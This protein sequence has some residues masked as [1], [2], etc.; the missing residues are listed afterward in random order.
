MHDGCQGGRERRCRA[1]ARSGRGERGTLA[2]RPGLP[3]AARPARLVLSVL[4]AGLA[5]GSA[6]GCGREGKPRA[7]NEDAVVDLDR[8]FQPLRLDFEGA[9]GK[10]RLIGIVGPTCGHCLESL[11]AIH[12]RLLER[13][14]GRDFEVFIVWSAVMPADVRVRARQHAERWA[15]PRIRHYWDDSGRVARAFGQHA[16]LPEGRPISNL[17]YLYGR[18]DTWDPGGAMANEPPGWNA[19]L[20]GWQPAAARARWGEHAHLRLPVFDTERI[21]EKTEELLAEPGR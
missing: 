19:I 6:A 14:S 21:A 18:D 13:V 7:A 15:D 11:T 16:G 2:R 1:S 5:L 17:F 12:G 4:L 9:A 3:A 20:E 10:V 8:S